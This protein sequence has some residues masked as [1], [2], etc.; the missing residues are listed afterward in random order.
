M[1]SLPF[2]PT[3]QFRTS[4]RVSLREMPFARFAET[5][6]S[7]TRFAVRSL[8]L[9]RSASIPAPLPVIEHPSIATP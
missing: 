1:P 6:E 7:T 4:R 9:R 3:V 5:V 2:S 8:D